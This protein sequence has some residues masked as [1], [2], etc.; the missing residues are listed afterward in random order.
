[1]SIEKLIQDYESDRQNCLKTTYNE[2]QLRSDFIDRFLKCLGWDVDNE[3]R[4]SQY[5]REVLQEEPIEVE[6]ENY[7]KILTIPYA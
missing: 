6:G 7:K 2:T 4:R 1:M 5:L 3:K